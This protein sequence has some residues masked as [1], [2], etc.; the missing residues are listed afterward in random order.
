MSKKTIMLLTFLA[1]LVF[2]AGC[3]T[4]NNTEN[5]DNKTN[6]IK[7]EQIPTVNLP[8]GFTFMAVHETDVEIANILKKAIEGIYRTDTGEDMYI[9]IFKTDSPEA[10]IS[11][12][13]SEYKD[14]GYDPFTEVY[15]NGHKA[16]RVMYY[17]TSNG[18]S[19]PK[20]NLV[21]AT[22]DSM[23]KVGP[24]LDAQKVINLATATN[25]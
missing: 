18:L 5:P 17:F 3:I 7:S 6:T 1:A 20:Y 19:S 12:Y 11:E 14:A 15:F 8:T 4:D 2:I 25:S 9:Q 10:L 13:K 22:K 24:S 23:I 21:W 16:T